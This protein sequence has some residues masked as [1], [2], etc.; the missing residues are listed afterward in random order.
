MSNPSTPK[1][2]VSLDDLYAALSAVTGEVIHEIA[3][4][5]LFLRQL[6]SPSPGSA[7]TAQE[8][9]TFAEQ[10]IARLERLLGNLRQF[11]LTVPQRQ[12]VRVVDVVK[13][14]LASLD[15]EP[16]EGSPRGSVDVPPSLAVNEDPE[17]LA[18]ALRNFLEHAR[19]AAGPAGAFG[20][21]ASVARADG[22]N[23]V[24][25]QIWDSGP[26]VP[27]AARTSLFVPWKPRKN[28]H[29]LRLAIARC[30]FRAMG[31]SVS[32]KRVEGRNEY[33]LIAPETAVEV[34]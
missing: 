13:P 22:T 11:K 17:F 34:Q 5:L 15:S 10:E 21:R 4:T 1:Q 16:T 9:A 32:Y 6:T 18:Q 20:L 2:M 33:S 29:S 31:W 8:T 12:P 30:V 24:R 19:E 14:I 3:H 23:T 28:N 27:A 26:E 7:T 25:L